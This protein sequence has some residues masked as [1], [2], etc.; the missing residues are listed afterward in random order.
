[1][2]GSWQPGLVGHT[3]IPGWFHH[4]TTEGGEGIIYRDGR[5]L[6]VRWP[7]NSEW[8]VGSSDTLT[9]PWSNGI[10]VSYGQCAPTTICISEADTLGM[11]ASVNGDYASM[12]GWQM[13]GDFYNNGPRTWATSSAVASGSAVVMIHSSN[14]AVAIFRNAQGEYEI[15]AQSGS[16][17]VTLFRNKV[18]SGKWSSW[19][20]GSDWAFPRGRD[21]SCAGA[22]PTPLPSASPSATVSPNPS[23]S[24]GGEG[25][26]LFFIDDKEGRNGAEPRSSVPNL[27]T[28]F[29]FVAGK[30]SCGGGWD[31]WSHRPGGDL[32]TYS[33]GEIFAKT[34]DSAYG[35]DI[36]R[37]VPKNAWSGEPDPNGDWPL[38]LVDQR[39]S[40]FDWSYVV[41]NDSVM[42]ASGGKISRVAASHSSDGKTTVAAKP[43]AGETLIIPL[44]WKQNNPLLDTG[45]YG[46]DKLVIQSRVSEAPWYF[47]IKDNLTGETLGIVGADTPLTLRKPTTAM[48]TKWG[49]ASGLPIEIALARNYP[50]FSFDRAGLGGSVRVAW[51]WGNETKQVATVVSGGPSGSPSPSPDSFTPDTV[52]VICVSGLGTNTAHGGQA[53][54]TY[55]AGVA[56]NGK[57]AWVD[58]DYPTYAVFPRAGGGYE[59]GMIGVYGTVSALATSSALTGNWSNGMGVS[60]GECGAG[61]SP[62]PGSGGIAPANTVTVCVKGGKDYVRP[63]NGIYRAATTSMGTAG[64]V[65]EGDPDTFITAEPGQSPGPSAYSIYQNSN[66]LYTG[67]VGD[68]QAWLVRGY[69]PQGMYPAPVVAAGECLFSPSPSPS[70]PLGAVDG[71]DPRNGVYYV[72]GEETTLDSN[73]NGW[74]GSSYYEGGQY[75]GNTGWSP[76]Y[77]A[78]FIDGEE[79]VLDGEGNGWNLGVFY[80][81]GQYEH[82]TGYDA[83]NGNL[84]VDGEMVES[85]VWSGEELQ[86]GE[87][88]AWLRLELDKPV[89]QESIHKSLEW[90]LHPQQNDDDVVRYANWLRSL[91]LNL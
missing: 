17:G 8:I 84:F 47:E 88:E 56:W 1:M 41:K 69:H 21:G 12:V 71:Y 31:D 18:L 28:D 54:G 49:T 15:R 46:W 38:I 80:W 55:R 73:G 2:I 68:G 6:H 77:G 23:A 74:M 45:E 7:Y 79:T 19:K 57:Q 53:N 25:R 43:K 81:N 65:M 89:S 87:H 78:Y 22:S 13:E 75:A 86:G 37:V 36:F 11:Y 44:V 20:L 67:T 63:I 14:P 91:N 58:V 66:I 61:S 24:P 26:V 60:I 42:L 64:W 83:R 50:N 51:D 40:P 48:V 85:D 52:P 30:D 33:G 70:W 90:V 5:Y 34:P 82:S 29:R 3:L 32:K 39:T 10:K 27:C 62:S 4:R 72:D 16:S 35:G 59:L 76:D 9:G